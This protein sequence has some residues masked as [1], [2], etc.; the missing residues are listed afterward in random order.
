MR[1]VWYQNF[2]CDLQIIVSCKPAIINNNPAATPN[3]AFPDIYCLA[4]N[5]NFNK[6]SLVLAWFK[7]IMSDVLQ[8]IKGNY[9]NYYYYIIPFSRRR[10]ENCQIARFMEVPAVQHV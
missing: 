4:R 8:A 3:N 1:L 10:F 2:R 6:M 5:I 7:I 9:N